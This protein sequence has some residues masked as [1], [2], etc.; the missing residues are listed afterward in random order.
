MVET[1]PITTKPNHLLVSD[2]LPQ[3]PWLYCLAPMWWCWMNTPGLGR[4]SASDF[5][6][7][8]WLIVVT[9]VTPSPDPVLLVKAPSPS[10]KTVLCHHCCVEELTQWLQALQLVFLDVVHLN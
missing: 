9:Q 8:G 2:V 3:C 1:Q 5:L 6:W 10:V 4:A 7:P